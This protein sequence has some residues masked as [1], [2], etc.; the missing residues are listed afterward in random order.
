MSSLAD[1]GESASLVD[2]DKVEA[3]ADDDEDDD[4][5]PADNGDAAA[6]PTC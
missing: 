2:G 5:E 4:D 1:E 3:D 6:V